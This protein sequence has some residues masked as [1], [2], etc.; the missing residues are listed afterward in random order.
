MNSLINFTAQEHKS[1]VTNIIKSY[2]SILLHR[3]SLANLNIFLFGAGDSSMYILPCI[4]IP[5]CAGMPFLS[6]LPFAYVL[7]R[8]CQV[9]HYLCARQSGNDAR[10]RITI[11]H[12]TKWCQAR[13]T[14]WKWRNYIHCHK[15]EKYRHP[16][17]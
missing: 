1:Y 15:Q 13:G 11:F 7:C 9:S 3:S 6:N 8:C 14:A 16:V 2:H 4:P 10:M 12:K 17:K 5:L